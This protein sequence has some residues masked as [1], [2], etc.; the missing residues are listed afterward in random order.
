MAM[1]DT[2]VA[3]RLTAASEEFRE[4]EAR[5][6]DPET[7]ADPSLLRSVSQRYRELEPLVGAWAAY[8]A[9]RRDLG[10]ARE[11]LVDASEPDDQEMAE[12][13]IGEA[14]AHL[15]QCD[16]TRHRP[17]R[18]AVGGDVVIHQRG[19]AHDAASAGRRPDGELRR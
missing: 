4:L 10:A 17:P 8:Q 16:L 9:R 5:L 18:R 6:A 1:L 12:D 14:E 15:G 19:Q 3:H 7:H 2:G 13:E 11:L